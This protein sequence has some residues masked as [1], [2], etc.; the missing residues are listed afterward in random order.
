MQYASNIDPKTTL[1]AAIQWGHET[2]VIA[3]GPRPRPA[4]LWNGSG[5]L[6]VGY[7]SP[8]ICQHT[9]G[10]LVKDVLLSH[11]ANRVIPFVYSSSP[12]QDWVTEEVSQKTQWREVGALNDEALA[13]CIQTDQID[14]LVDLAG[15]TAGS[16]LSVFARR[17]AP[18]LVSWL[19]YFA[20]TGLSCM[21]AVLLDA[22]HAPPG[23]ESD[24]VEA[25][26]RMPQGRWCYTPAPWTPLFPMPRTPGR[27]FTFGSFNNTNKYNPDLYDLWAEVLTAVP[28]S[29]LLLKWRTFSDPSFAVATKEAFTSRGIAPERIELREFS[30]HSQ[31]L[32]EYADVDVA[33]DPRP[34]SGGLTTFECLWSGVPVITWP[35]ERVVSRQTSSILQSIG[36]GDWIAHSAQGYVDITQRLANDLEQLAVVRRGLRND[37]IRSGVMSAKNFTDKY[38]DVLTDLYLQFSKLP[39]LPS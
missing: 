30:T 11:N 32:L 27:P 12:L 22:G 4:F 17:P 24:F 2:T 29:H 39:V 16:R 28:G 14:I 38:E 33:L 9:V 25:L 21:D 35:Q 23:T 3:G 37:M 31:L 34:F 36:R 13:Q 15:H 8:D 5:P 26:V 20:T 19:G 1:A 10:L 7:V 6:R 18:V